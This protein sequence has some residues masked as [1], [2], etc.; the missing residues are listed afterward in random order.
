MINIICNIMLEYLRIR[1][2]KICPSTFEHE[3]RIRMALCE[4][5]RSYTIKFKLEVIRY[6][7]NHSKAEASRRYG[8]HR[9]LVQM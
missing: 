1:N 6:T 3:G 7:F 5:F 2:Y 9:K 8:V 4:K